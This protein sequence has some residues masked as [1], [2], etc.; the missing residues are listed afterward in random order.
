MSDGWLPCDEPKRHAP[1]DWTYTDPN[2]GLSSGA[3]C[4][5]GQVR[6]APERQCCGDP[7]CPCAAKPGWTTHGAGSMN[8]PDLNDPDETETP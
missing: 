3:Y 2:T 5:G 8:Y 1:H 4:D 6:P 7:L